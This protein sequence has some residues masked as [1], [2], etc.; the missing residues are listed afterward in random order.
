M[1]NSN[2]FLFLLKATAFILITF[3]VINTVK[4]KSI[5]KLVK[6]AEKARKELFEKEDDGEFIEI[7][8]DI[9]K[10][11]KLTPVF[12]SIL[13]LNYIIILIS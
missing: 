2:H 6:K 9:Y 8:D 4:P 1:Y 13:L 3:I 11:L 5:L 10:L 7:H 12:N